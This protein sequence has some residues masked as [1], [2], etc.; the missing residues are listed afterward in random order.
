MKKTIFIVAL[1]IVANLFTKAQGTNYGEKVDFSSVKTFEQF[2]QTTKG[3]TE[4]AAT[5]VGAVTAVCQTE[6]C[7]MK[8][9][10]G[11]GTTMMVKVKDHKFALPKDIAGHKAV[12]SGLATMKTTSVEQLKHYAEDEGKSKDYINSIKEPVSEWVFEATGITIL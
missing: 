12:F 3:K 1:V 6:G 9:D 4:I 2:T 11:D 7:W 8:V 10:K 5:L